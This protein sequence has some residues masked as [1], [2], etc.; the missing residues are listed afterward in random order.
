MI[1][2]YCLMMVLVLVMGHLTVSSSLDGVPWPSRAGPG[3][4]VS[5]A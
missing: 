5:L 3:R 1:V 2:S 4:F